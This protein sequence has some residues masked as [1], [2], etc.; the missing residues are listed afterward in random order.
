MARYCAALLVLMFCFIVSCGASQESGESEGEGSGKNQGVPA[1]PKTAAQ[2]ESTP[3]SSAS[4]SSQATQMPTPSTQIGEVLPPQDFD[5]RI[6]EVA[7]LDEYT[8]LESVYFDE[9]VDEVQ[10]LPQAGKFVVVSYSVR[11]TGSGPLN[12]GFSATLSTDSGEFYEE[13]DDAFH[14]NALLDGVSGGFELQP[15]GMEVGQFIFDIPTDVEPTTLT[16]GYTNLGESASASA[17]NGSQ[18]GDVDLTRR[19]EPGA[20]PD[21]VL[22][23]QYE[24]ANMRAW[25]L[26]YDFF[27]EESKDLISFEQYSSSQGSGAPVA[28]TEYSFPSVEVQ[29]DRAVIERIFTAEDPSGEGQYDATQEAVLEDGAWKIIMR[30]DQIELFSSEMQEETTS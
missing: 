18:A 6:L 25:D 24:Y 17:M 27:A 1:K 29:G 28:I 11:N 30:Q 21:E 26:A 5:L 16:L 10:A 12:V 3:A 20:P 4:Q 8:Y 7:V 23:L 19:A 22:A 14:P 13:S 15:R 2:S 9:T